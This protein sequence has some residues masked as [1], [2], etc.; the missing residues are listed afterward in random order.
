MGGWVGEREGG[1]VDG[2]MGGWVD[3]WMGGWVDV[4]AALVATAKP[5]G[6]SPPTGIGEWVEARHRRTKRSWV[7]PRH[8]ADH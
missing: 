7:V 8:S 4:G 3:G 6:R 1:W 5:R 2:W